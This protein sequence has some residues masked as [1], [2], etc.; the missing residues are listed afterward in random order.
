MSD[1]T[2][3]F[4]GFLLGVLFGIFPDDDYCTFSPLYDLEQRMV[5]YS[6]QLTS[7]NYYVVKVLPLIDTVTLILSVKIMK[8]IIL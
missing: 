2:C 6:L 3:S 1:R 8:S 7:S 5:V 4:R